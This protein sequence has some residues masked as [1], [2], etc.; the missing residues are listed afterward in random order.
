MSKAALDQPSASALTKELLRSFSSDVLTVAEPGY[1][2]P[3]TIWNAMVE[4]GLPS[5]LAARPRATL[6]PPSTLPG[7]T[8]FTDPDNFYRANNAAI[9]PAARRSAVAP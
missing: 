6:P 8:S 4:R 3:L 1:D 7:G 2:E 5:S 9:A